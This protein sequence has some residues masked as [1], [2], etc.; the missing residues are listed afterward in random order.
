MIPFH[1][2]KAIGYLAFLALVIY[3]FKDDKPV[4]GHDGQNP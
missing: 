1:F 4:K 2:F 3:S